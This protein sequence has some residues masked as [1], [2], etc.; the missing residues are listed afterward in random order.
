MWLHWWLWL[1]WVIQCKT[2]IYMYLTR[3]PQYIMNPK[4]L[5]I[6]PYNSTFYMILWYQGQLSHVGMSMSHPTGVVLMF[7]VLSPPTM[8]VIAPSNSPDTIKCNWYIDTKQPSDY[9]L[10]KKTSQ[11]VVKLQW[12][13][14]WEKSCYK[15]SLIVECL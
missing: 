15:P 14:K 13:L 3:A 6:L 8:S 1:E 5:W 9:L 4:F 11:L 7:T 2:L 10:L 12:I